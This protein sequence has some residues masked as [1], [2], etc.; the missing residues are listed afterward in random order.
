GGTTGPAGAEGCRS[1]TPSPPAIGPY[2]VEDAAWIVDDFGTGAS[3]WQVE[4]WAN[5]ATLRVA[6]GELKIEL[7][8]G[9]HDKSAIARAATLDLSDRSKLILDV[10]NDGQKDVKVAIAFTTGGANTFFETEQAT[11][12]PGLNKNIAFDLKSEKFKSQAT[13]W[14]HSAKISDANAVKRVIILIYGESKGVL[15]LDNIRFEK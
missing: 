2:K 1:Q 13:E 3:Y 6:D 9:K 14:K 7:G 12:K 10:R 11:A 5:P 8:E 4:T 15:C